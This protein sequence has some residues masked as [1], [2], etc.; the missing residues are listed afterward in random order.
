MLTTHGIA[1]KFKNKIVY[2]MAR[3]IVVAYQGLNFLRHE[4]VETRWSLLG[5]FIY[6]IYA[7]NS[8]LEIFIRDGQAKSACI[9]ISQGWM[10]LEVLAS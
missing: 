4:K 6:S 3:A 2:E 7:L 5:G 9:S 10:K 1:S 8:M